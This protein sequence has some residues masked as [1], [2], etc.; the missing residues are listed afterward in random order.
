MILLRHT[1]AKA[2]QC[3]G[4]AKDNAKSRIRLRQTN[5]KAMLRQS[6]AKPDQWQGQAEDKAKAKRS[7]QTKA[8]A[9]RQR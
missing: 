1:K 3:Q 4:Q 9:D 7:K 8:R 6:K 2:D 5:G